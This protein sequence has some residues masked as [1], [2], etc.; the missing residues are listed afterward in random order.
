MMMR[1]DI[2][3]A[4]LLLLLP[5]I[6]LVLALVCLPVVSLGATEQSFTGKVIGVECSAAGII[7]KISVTARKGITAQEAT[8]QRRPPVEE[9]RLD[10]SCQTEKSSIWKFIHQKTRKK[11]VTVR[12]SSV[13]RGNHPMADVLLPGNQSLTAVIEASFPSPPLKN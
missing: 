12:F 8:A 7:V 4:G 9:V 5:S 1:K 2:S 10:L 3:R 11:V 6:V 13:D